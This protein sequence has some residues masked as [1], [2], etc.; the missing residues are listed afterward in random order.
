LMTE[1]GSGN[2]DIFLLF[3]LDQPEAS[4]HPPTDL[5]TYVASHP[6]SGPSAIVTSAWEVFKP[7]AARSYLAIARRAAFG[8]RRL[9]YSPSI[10]P[11]L[12]RSRLKR[13]ASAPLLQR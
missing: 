4:V 3:S 1:G 8:R 2:A 10:N 7:A 9:N 12:S 5:Y 11:T 13:R 6:S